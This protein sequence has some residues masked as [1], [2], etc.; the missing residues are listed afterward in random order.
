[1]VAPYF[2]QI[3]GRGLRGGDAEEDEPAEQRRHEGDASH[4]TDAKAA[5]VKRPTGAD[6][7]RRRPARS[8]ETYS[9]T[10]SRKRSSSRSC[11]TGSFSHAHAMPWTTFDMSAWV[12]SARTTPGLLR[13]FEQVGADGEDDLAR[14]PQR[15]VGVVDRHG[16]LGGEP[17]GGGDV[18][19]LGQQPRPERGSRGRRSRGCARWS[20]SPRSRRG[21]RPRSGPAGSGS[22]GRACRRRHRRPSRC[23]PATP[24]CPS[25]RTPPRP[26]SAGARNCDAHRPSRQTPLHKRRQPPYIYRSRPPIILSPEG[27]PHEPRQRITLLVIA[28]AQLMLILDGTIVTVALP[29]IQEELGFSLEACRG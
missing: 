7:F 18:A 10:P 8:L 9:S 3:T 5:R 24:R 16:E 21:A 28:L 11:R 27:P 12:R 13:L 25:P 6:P 17:P 2:S 22:A 14:S 15:G 4:A 19:H 26:R 29:G 23:P 20:P 1:M